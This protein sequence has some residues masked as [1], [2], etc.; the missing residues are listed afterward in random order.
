MVIFIVAIVAS[1]AIPRFSASI[2]RQRADAA[3]RRV[4]ADLALARRYASQTSTSVTVGFDVAA[5]SYRLS[6]VPD[7]DRPGDEYEVRLTDELCHATI[8]S[9]D[10]GGQPQVAFDG[11]GNVTGA[12]RSGGKLLIRVGSEQRVV[13]L[14]GGTK[15]VG[16][17]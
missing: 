13:T 16:W 17:Q 8:V 6:G 10:F 7:P 14:D 15:Q 11:Y 4:V 3:A 9:A 1:M 5:S 12:A 2:S